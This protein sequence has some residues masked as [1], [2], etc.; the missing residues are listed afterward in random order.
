MGG[1]CRPPQPRRSLGCDHDELAFAFRPF[2]AENQAC[3]DGLA[4]ADFIGKDDAFLQRVGDGEQGG[5]DLMGV[6]VDLGVE[7]CGAEAIKL[8]DGAQPRE[9]VGEVAGL[10]RRGGNLAGAS[11]RDWFA[12]TDWGWSTI[13]PDCLVGLMCRY[14]SNDHPSTCHVCPPPEICCG[15]LKG[16]CQ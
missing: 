1:P 8:A 14:L 13:P 2:L 9:L 15:N 4:E 10:M 16:E 11:Q 12:Q 3:L 6:K 5:L 7:Q